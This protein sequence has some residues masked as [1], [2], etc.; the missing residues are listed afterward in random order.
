MAG[1]DEISCRNA[2]CSLVSPKSR[3]ADLPTMRCRPRGYRPSGNHVAGA[4]RA[5]RDSLRMPLSAAPGIT[6]RRC[7]F[8]D[9]L[10]SW[11][12]VADNE[13]KEIYVQRRTFRL[14]IA[15]A[16][17]AAG[18]GAGATAATQAWGQ[19]APAI[20]AADGGTERAASIP[21][22]S[23]IWAHLTWPDVEPPA[24]GPGPVTNR[25]R[26]NGVERHLS[27]GR[28]LHQSDLEAAGGGSREETR[29]NLIDRRALSDPEQPVLARRRALRF[30][31]YRDADA[32]A[33]ATRSRSSI[34]T[35]MKSATCA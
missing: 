23:G 5:R 14:L 24:A 3:P 1:P 7:G 25:A 33:A 4:L 8:W 17:M 18:A 19:S 26:R 31:E 28:R 9:N 11:K 10:C 20:G 30:L 6:V 29:R 15:V 21:D 32:P 12:S 13:R 22:F 16:A 34:P 35:I 27:A 2:A